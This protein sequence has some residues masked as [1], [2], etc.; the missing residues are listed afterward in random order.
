MRDILIK[1]LMVL[2]FLGITVPL[3]P[4]VGVANTTV[5]IEETT[6]FVTTDGSDVVVK[7]GTYAVEAAGEWL[8]LVQGERRNALLLEAD[9]IQHEEN[10]ETAKALSQSR[11]AGVHRL[12]LL[13]PGGHGL[14]AIGSVSG[15][16]SRAVRR[17]PST[18]RSVQQKTSPSFTQSKKRT[19]IRQSKPRTTSPKQPTDPLM[20]RVHN[21]EQLVGTLQTTI[22]ALQNRLTKMESAVQVDNAGNM[23][24]TLPAKFKI[25]AS[26]VEI[27][28]GMIKA[29]AALSKFSGV[30][31]ADTVNTNSVISKTYTPG[32]GNVW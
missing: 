15:V 4:T 3:F 26:V 28:A 32:A 1:S 6:H 11:E 14:E 21:L 31:K 20:Q 7:P 22:T 9:H 16:R 27:N 12:V 23:T 10:I 24:M 5:L 17:A 8:Q 19:V 29:N 25:N 18:R 2:T 30:V 13:L